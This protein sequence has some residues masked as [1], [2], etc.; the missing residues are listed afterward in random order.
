[1]VSSKRWNCSI[2]K[3][4]VSNYISWFAWFPVWKSEP[5]L[6]N[7]LPSSTPTFLGRV[8]ASNFVVE[9]ALGGKWWRRCVWACFHTLCH[10][11]LLKFHGAIIGS[12][13][14]KA[15]RCIFRCLT[16]VVNATDPNLSNLELPIHHTIITP[17]LFCLVGEWFSLKNTWCHK[18]SYTY[19]TYVCFECA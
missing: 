9:R 10:Q 13:G 18:L 8:V 6:P 1:M 15:P 16:G 17:T 12:Y 5:P 3:R 4:F 7:Q 19:I 11:S 14:G 2:C